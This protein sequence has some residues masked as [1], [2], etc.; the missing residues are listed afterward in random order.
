MNNDIRWRGYMWFIKQPMYFESLLTHN[1]LNSWVSRGIII[2]ED[3]KI[4][5]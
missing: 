2:K 3:F 5:F 1:K 4:L